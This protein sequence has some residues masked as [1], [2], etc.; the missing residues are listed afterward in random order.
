M[1]REW[2]FSGSLKEIYSYVPQEL[3]NNSIKK[4][5]KNDHL[6]SS[7]R[8]TVD[9]DNNYIFRSGVEQWSVF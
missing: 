1:E 8:L 2:R 6:E 4:A 9:F 7:K 5:V 3:K